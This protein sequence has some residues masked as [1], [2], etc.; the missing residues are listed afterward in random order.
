MAFE[1]GPSLGPPF[2]DV[3]GIPNFRDIGGYC[4]SQP[5][6][7]VRKGLVYR[8][9]DPGG[10]KG[11]GL[12]KMHSELGIRVIFD[13]R[14][15]PEIKRDGPEWAGIEIDDVN[16]IASYN[17]RREWT[18]VYENRNSNPEKLAV[19]YKDYT[20]TKVEGFEKAYQ[21]IATCA[22]DA[23]GKIFRHLAQDNPDPCLI[24]CTAGKDRTGVLVAMLFMLVGVD[25]ETIADE[26][27]LTDKGLAHL[28]ATFV[29]RLLKNP[30][31]ENDQEAVERMISSKRENMLAA[32]K[33]IER[34]FGG[35]EKYMRTNCKMN[36][37][38]IESV[39]K[40]LLRQA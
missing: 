28:K 11:P 1:S 14:S 13:L 20:S 24:H 22:P 23:Y 40:N 17:L 33:M 18:P 35:T 19:R 7:H 29:E 39:R 34:E 4:T 10:A 36:A 5:D 21:D 31:F 2:I 32:V 25:P 9:A 38:E 15:A 37:D 12:E 27:S 30:V 16:N 6:G 3:D 8:S 26:Y